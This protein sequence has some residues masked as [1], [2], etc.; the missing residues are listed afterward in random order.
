MHYRTPR[1]SFLE[2]EE[3]F[4]GLFDR[5]ERPEEPS[6]ETADLP[7]EGPVLVVPAAP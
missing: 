6:F 2:T 5:V 7:G 3:G 4:A 1:I